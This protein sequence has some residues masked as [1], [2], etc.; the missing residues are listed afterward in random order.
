MRYQSIKY[1]ISFAFVIVWHCLAYSQPYEAKN[2]KDFKVKAEKYFEEEDYDAAYK[3][4]SQLV[5]N[6]PK[7]PI[8]NY[9]LGVSMLFAEPDKTK[10]KK[11]LDFA[12]QYKTEIPKEH[13]FY[14]GKYYHYNYEFDQAI[15]FY[16]NYKLLAKKSDIDRLK[17]ENEIKA[18]ESGK[19]LLNRLSDLTVL[20]KKELPRSD[21]FLSYDFKNL[22]GRLIAKPAE[23]KSERDLKNKDNSVAFIST[24]TDKLF[25]S[26]YNTDKTKGKDIYVVKKKGNGWGSPQNISAI[27]TEMDEDFPFFH[28][29]G[30]TLYFASK[31]H[32]TMGGYDIFKSE[33]DAT[34]DTWGVPVNLD[35]PINTPLD[36]ILFAT[37]SAEKYAYF[38]SNRSSE[39]NN[40]TIYKINTLRKA[41]E[42]I[43]IQGASVK[44]K[45]TESNKSAITVVNKSTGEVF[46]PITATDGGKYVLQI[47]NGG[48]FDFTVE[49]PGFRSQT[50]EVQLKQYLDVRPV[51]QYI[52]YNEG[53]LSIKTYLDTSSANNYARLL[54]L[55]KQRANL[56]I[57][58]GTNKT[59]EAPLAEIKPD[60]VDATAVVKKPVEEVKP[61]IV[62]EQQIIQEA[63]DDASKAK[64]EASAL[65]NAY[66]F[67]KQ[68]LDEKL[69]AKSEA[70]NELTQIKE[71]QKTAGQADSV[72]FASAAINKQNE[73]NA[74]DEQV[75]L[76][77]GLNAE[78]KTNA[79]KK[80]KEAKLLDKYAT[81]IALVSKA[82][83]KKTALNN[84]D[85]LQKEL[86]TAGNNIRLSKDIIEEYTEKVNQKA[87]EGEVFKQQV[88]TLQNDI[89]DFTNEKEKLKEDQAA[90]KDKDLKAT[91]QSQI[92]DI[93]KDLADKTTRLSTLQQQAE[94]AS[95]NAKNTE[96]L[97]TVLN[98]T[99][100]AANKTEP[101]ASAD[102][103]TNIEKTDVIE[104]K[105]KAAVI[106]LSNEFL[107]AK[108][109]MSFPADKTVNDL[110]L[111]SLKAENTKVLNYNKAIDKEITLKKSAIVKAKATEDKNR[112]QGLMDDLLVQRQSNSKLLAEIKER[113]LALAPKV[114]TLPAASTNVIAYSPAYELAKKEGETNAALVIKT[115]DETALKNQSAKI[116]TWNKAIDIELQKQKTASAKYKL[117]EE[118]SK[119]SDLMNDLKIQKQSNNLLLTE[120]I[121]LQKS[122]TKTDTTALAVTKP[123]L[124]P[125]ETKPTTESKVVGYTPKFDS[126]RSNYDTALV[127][128]VSSLDVVELA[129][130]KKI[131]NAYNVAID[132]EI[133]AKK[134]GLA[135]TANADEK[136]Q[137][138][139]MVNQLNAKKK[140]NALLI[141]KINEKQSAINIANTNTKQPTVKQSAITT[142]KTVITKPS[143]TLIP[144][145]ASNEVANDSSKAGDYVQTQLKTKTVWN[146]ATPNLV[147]SY[148]KEVTDEPIYFSIFTEDIKR[149][150]KLNT[151]ISALEL[152]KAKA[153]SA[154]QLVLQNT[155][156]K[157]KSTITVFKFDLAK[158]TR[159]LNR[160][161]FS[162]NKTKLKTQIENFTGST[163]DREMGYGLMAY[164]DK[165]L[166]EA[167]AFRDS[168]NKV[169]DLDKKLFLISLAEQ[170][171]KQGLEGLESAIALTKPF[172]AVKQDSTAI[173]KVNPTTPDAIVQNDVSA[174]KGFNTT[175]SIKDAPDLKTIDLNSLSPEKIVE[176]K[177]A[178]EYKSYANLKADAKNLETSAKSIESKV[179][180]IKGVASR[181]DNTIKS[182]KTKPGNEKK[183]TDLENANSKL[184]LQA[185]SLT[186]IVFNTK[187]AA[188]AKHLE[189]DLMLYS[190]DET[191]AAEIV[192][193][194]GFKPISQRP[195]QLAN[196]SEIE[197]I[198]IDSAKIKSDALMAR[199]DSI[200]ATTNTK[201]ERV[202]PTETTKVKESITKQA[203]TL[204]PFGDAVEPYT[205][206][207]VDFN[208]NGYS[209]SNPIPIDQTMPEG[210]IFKV[211][212]GAFKTRPDDN[213][214][215]NI[216][217]IAGETTASGYTRYTAGF[218][219]AFP[220][221]NG[222]KN[223]LSNK[224]FKDAYVVAYYNGKR[225]SLDSARRIKGTEPVVV[226]VTPT[227]V[228][229][230]VQVTKQP[231]YIVPVQQGIETRAIEVQA[232]L[233][234]TVQIGAYSRIVTKKDLFNLDPIYTEKRSSTLYSFTTGLYTTLQE[235]IVRKNFAVSVG[236]KDAFVRA[237]KDGKRITLE[238]ARQ[239][240]AGVLPKATAPVQNNVPAE[241]VIE[242]VPVT[243]KPTIESTPANI[244]QPNTSDGQSQ[245]NV[246]APKARIIL[247]DDSTF[248][249]VNFDNGITTY[250]IPDAE[251]G[252]KLEDNGVCFRVQVGVFQ[253]ELPEENK[254]AFLKI[255]KWPIRGFRF[256]NG[257]TK[258]NVGNFNNPVSAN[259]LKQEVLAAGV[260]DAF[261]IAYYDNKRISVA[262]AMKI[263]ENGGK[264][265]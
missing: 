196:N 226:K 151:E 235:A 179:N 153:V 215:G 161:A 19:N 183:I 34:N 194:S 166:A 63:K 262:E 228:A 200:R 221:A 88:S 41:P 97:L 197:K 177:S 14:L 95:A 49:T 40:F 69:K 53:L 62:S 214:F 83:D 184:N 45:D 185:D 159:N 42:L 198:I 92:D 21:F 255:K 94:T 32:N 257:L 190:L 20:D 118:K 109:R 82:K 142:P 130:Q 220:S 68:A 123:P 55:I 16:D 134:S 22:G 171:E 108:A 101:V 9:R 148:Y 139:A 181:N 25:I 189:A 132:K 52:T 232:G 72:S 263:L 61:A 140:E 71:A 58:T 117:A 90:T 115:L 229:T 6:F 254:N 27:N 122:I 165:R 5:A 60:K 127:K 38:A 15:K 244:S 251:N 260:A 250:P 135:S 195:T 67:S 79:D 188:E 121:A 182:L 206:N 113:E 237:F 87:N 154:K 81:D 217:P 176:V 125:A 224:G 252:V 13:L 204:L 48:K 86:E 7:D 44:V 208:G 66:I 128:D 174:N 37:D 259:A 173:A 256:S 73:V 65:T 11:Y 120:N 150:D 241:K 106:Q 36:D 112:L 31:G 12:A 239:I 213:A 249:I 155:I 187:A 78:L 89:K 30:K 162:R 157:K 17:V 172:V 152:Q 147:K 160:I 33:Y 80:E 143:T 207:Q 57:D 133:L 261:V 227:N 54:E 199:L 98:G 202:R 1:I 156:D 104:T 231:D 59:P 23:F 146:N 76:L 39:G 93:E 144:A 258:Y 119:V 2:Q 35:F 141:N 96:Q 170:K 74:I 211:Q 180:N 24:N 164:S 223:D 169:V 138:I 233:A 238:E 212:I 192:A 158:N 253:G 43:V 26:N 216:T 50:Q 264:R 242:I 91:Y 137:L 131:V 107:T 218:F 99:N 102:T 222:A 265:Q 70:E 18:C 28:P 225:I 110:D 3:A 124:N 168:A 175:A 111:Q 105:P 230:K 246:K 193:V 136:G 236:V 186:E 145:L 51:L 247:Y 210:L 56:N 4:Y 77:D 248:T 149:I 209:K 103:P 129:E 116:Q 46:G 219:D 167:N 234:Y 114:E 64:G 85:A 240:E 205:R 203:E 163:E 245:P 201:P 8:F 243:T 178:I 29:N 100:D 191:K 47:A 126:L 10:A 75:K 84:L